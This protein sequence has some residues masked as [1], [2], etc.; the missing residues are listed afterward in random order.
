MTTKELMKRIGINANTEQLNRKLL[1]DS[2]LNTLRGIFKGD[3][4]KG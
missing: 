4:L 1:N 2:S 3:L